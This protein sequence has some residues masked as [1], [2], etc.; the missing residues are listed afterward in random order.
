MMTCRELTEFLSDYL[1]GDLPD[2]T[3][4]TFEFHMRLCG[5][6]REFIVQ[7]RQTVEAAGHCAED[8]AT[9][10]TALPEEVVRAIMAAVKEAPPP[11]RR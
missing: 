5:A 9:I 2:Q 3:T 7:F 6:C 11:K 4:R 1:A 8:P 10:R